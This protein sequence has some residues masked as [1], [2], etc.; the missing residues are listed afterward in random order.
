MIR[1]QG[2][3]VGERKKCIEVVKQV[4]AVCSFRNILNYFS[5][6][7]F[8][9]QASLFVNKINCSFL[10][11]KLMPYTSSILSLVLVY[12]LVSFSFLR[13]LENSLL[14]QIA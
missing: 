9:Q 4:H 2:F 6:D 13:S 8:C 3:C 11:T 5:V 1:N 12:Q 10:T 14:L 7:F